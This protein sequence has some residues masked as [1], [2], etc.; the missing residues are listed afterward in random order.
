MPENALLSHDLFEGLYARTALVTDVEVVDD[1]PVERARAR[2][3]AAP[4]GARRLAD[5]AGGCFRS[6]R[7]ATGVAAQ[8]PAAHLALEDPRQPAAQ[9]DRAGAA[10]I[11]LRRLDGAARAPL[12]VDADGARGRV[13]AGPPDA[14]PRARRALVRTTARCVPAAALGR[15]ADRRGTGSASR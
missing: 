5:P 2:A 9:P 15:P 12:G 4:L 11:A 1:Y 8:S 10:R 7:R 3:P 14:G 13:L 6:C